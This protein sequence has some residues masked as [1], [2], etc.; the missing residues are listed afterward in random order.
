MTLRRRL[1]ALERSLGRR[2]DL[3]S[4]HAH[5]LSSLSDDG[6]SR[7]IDAG[8][9]CMNGQ[10]TPEHVTLWQQHRQATAGMASPFDAWSVEELDGEIRR[11]TTGWEERAPWPA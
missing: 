7:L 2:D 9:A 10:G 8:L 6:L 4:Q 11:L 5:V 1:D 3:F